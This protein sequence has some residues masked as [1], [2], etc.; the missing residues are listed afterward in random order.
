MEGSACLSSDWHILLHKR[1]ASPPQGC[2]QGCLLSKAVT[3]VTIYSPQTRP[4]P[5]I[6]PVYCLLS[7]HTYQVTKMNALHAIIGRLCGGPLEEETD[8]V[9]DVAEQVF[10]LIFNAEK[11]G[12]SL[13]AQI[14]GKVHAE[15][16]TEKIAES[17]LA[18]LQ[19]VIEQG[20]NDMGPAMREAV[21]TAS[22]VVQDVFQLALDHPVATTVFCTLVALAILVLISPW[23]IEA[24]G[25]GELGPIEGDSLST[26]NIIFLLTLLLSVGSFAAGW[27]STYRGY[28]SKDSLFAF[29]QRLRM[30]WR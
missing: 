3:A 13:R 26:I 7:I 11:N 21:D 25:F 8:R 29:F 1:Q 10:Q 6:H 30:A 15:G 18:K 19:Q 23:I 20:R 27:Q 24:L 2:L 9:E 14:K 28:V 16:W 12:P 5:I 4:T 17:I 22:T